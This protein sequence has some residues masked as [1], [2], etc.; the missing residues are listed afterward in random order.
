MYLLMLNK[1]R[2][3]FYAL[4]NKEHATNVNGVVALERNN[5]V[6]NYK[7]KKWRA[8]LEEHATKVVK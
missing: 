3:N 8:P 4:S 6:S 2:R 5:V 1:S 7:H